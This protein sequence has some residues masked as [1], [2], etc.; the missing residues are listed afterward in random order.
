[1][2]VFY[3]SILFGDGVPPRSSIFCTEAVIR[4]INHNRVK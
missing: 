4:V 3:P 1:M 2:S